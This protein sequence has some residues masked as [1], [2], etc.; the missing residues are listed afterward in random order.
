MRQGGV[1]E[2][3]EHLHW[4]VVLEQQG[5]FSK[6]A[7][8][9]GVSKASMSQHI[10][11]LETAA[12]VMLVQRTTRSAMLTAAGRELVD[13]V[14]GAFDQIATSF[15]NVRDL[16]GAPRGRLRVTAP[17]AFARQQLVP[18][19]PAFL[20]RFP[21][22]QVELDM[23]DRIRPLAQEGFDLAVRHTAA[24]PETHVAWTLASTR[25]VLAA[26]RSYLRAN[27]LP[28]SPME[29]AG[30]ACLHY[31]RAQGASTWT[32]VSSDAKY[33]DPVTVPVAGQLAVNNSEALRDA[34]IAG[35][36]IALLPDFSAQ[37]ALQSGRL[38]EV[39]PDWRSTGAFGEWLYAIRPYA[40]HA[41]RVSQVFVEFLREAYAEGFAPR[42]PD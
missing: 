37:S 30:H 27:G 21:D 9:L 6:A 26:S 12:G 38:V 36:G 14:Q 1:E 2:L 23:S 18:L 42:K 10:S 16:A 34:A 17:V 32:F 8:R 19:L 13:S 3:W 11:A 33:A 39:L 7:A 5:S 20:R 40:A 4:L 28:E 24:P 25:T 22:I 35:L 15:A 41:S 31:P 29:L